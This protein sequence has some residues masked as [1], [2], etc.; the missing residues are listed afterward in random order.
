MQRK[1]PRN[2]TASLSPSVG[3][4][5][6]HA[7]ENA[8]QAGESRSSFVDRALAARNEARSTGEYLTASEVLGELDE[9]HAE[10]LARPGK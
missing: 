1:G 6:R 9:L 5:P 10:T 4:R 8:A 3:T 2:K 7:S